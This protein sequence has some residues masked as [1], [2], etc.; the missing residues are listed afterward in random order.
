M[1]TLNT[2]TASAEAVAKLITQGYGAT[3]TYN[4]SIPVIPDDLTDIE[5]QELMRLFQHFV[6]YNNFLLLQISCARIDE[7][8]ATKDFDRYEAS[9]LL[10]AV[11]GETVARTKAKVISSPEG[12]ALEDEL[13][14]RRNY[15]SLLKSIQDG[16][17]ESTKVISRELSRRTANPGFTSRKF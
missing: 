2:G 16:V 7:E 4:D 14:V 1:I 9:M 3:T 8:N 17:T 5:D 13:A 11:K 6:E 10:Q 15:H 12:Q